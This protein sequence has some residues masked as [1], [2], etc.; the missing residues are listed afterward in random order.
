MGE[1]YLI[2]AAFAA[3]IVTVT[4][5]A[6]I[7]IHS[8]RVAGAAGRIPVTNP[9]TAF[10]GNT[11]MRTAVF[12]RLPSRSGVARGAICAERAGME[13]R[14]GMTGNTL[15]RSPGKRI[16]HVAPFAA[17]IHMRAG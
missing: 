6:G 14:V 2:A 8:I 10:I 1:C 16:I 3:L 5:Q 12:R 17:Y 7:V 13:N 9:E 15:G 4:G 11:G